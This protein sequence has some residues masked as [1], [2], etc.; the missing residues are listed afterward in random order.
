MSWLLSLKRKGS[1]TRLRNR[2]EAEF[3]VDQLLEET[4]GDDGE[5]GLCLG[6]GGLSREDT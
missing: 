1:E 2:A 5:L 4:T 3:G 6:W